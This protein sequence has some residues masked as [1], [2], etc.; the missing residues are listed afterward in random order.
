[1]PKTA[2]EKKKKKDSVDILFVVFI[3]VLSYKLYFQA[4]RNRHIICLFCCCFL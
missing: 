1:M 3:K 2:C 4:N